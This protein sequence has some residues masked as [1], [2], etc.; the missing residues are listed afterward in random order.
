M[1]LSPKKLC[2]PNSLCQ[3]A[4]MYKNYILAVLYNVI[5]CQVMPNGKLLYSAIKQIK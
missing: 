1:I 4:V 2:L 5:T 3:K